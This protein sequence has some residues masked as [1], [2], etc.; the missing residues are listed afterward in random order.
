[1]VETTTATPLA[2]SDAGNGEAAA[3]FLPGWCGGREVF[4]PALEHTAR[5][6][7]AISV[8]WP[9]HGDTPNT[10]ADF[11]TG[12]LVNDAVELIDEL[13]IDHVVP[14]ALSHA[15]W[16]ALEL[17]RRLGA[18]R[19]PGVVL[20]DWMP[21]GPPPGFTGALAALQDPGRWAG[22]RAGL[23]AMWVHGVTDPAIHDY[24]DSMSAYGYPM[25]S[26][27]G[28][29][30]QR[31]FAACPVPLSAFAEFARDGAPCPTLHLYAQPRDDAYL[32][33]QQGFAA[34]HHWFQVRRL[35]ASSHFPCLEVP[36]QFT[37]AVDEFV[38]GLG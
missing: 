27:A 26:R 24:I 30:I 15:G 8:D 31:A 33:A 4:A 36:E 21:L 2:H 10:D 29:E 13:G 38:T 35:E 25:W 6:R 18:R 1:M 9:G 37:A 28:R 34:E 23:F 22:T 3:L 16:V 12:D 19:V 17:R 32:A 7:R 11:G 14:V 5:T 20:L